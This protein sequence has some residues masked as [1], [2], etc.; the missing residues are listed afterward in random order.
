MTHVATKWYGTST[1]PSDTT[2]TN[3]RGE[4]LLTRSGGPFD[5]DTKVYLG[6]PPH[7]YACSGGLGDLIDRGE[8][9]APF[10]AHYMYGAFIEEQISKRK[11][12]EDLPIFKDITGR[13]VM[14]PREE[15]LNPDKIVTLLNIRAKISILD[16]HNA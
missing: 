5:Y 1:L 6:T 7:C 11:D 8:R 2:S 4:S 10:S 12:I 14:L 9:H 16:A 13:R 15:Q 3:A